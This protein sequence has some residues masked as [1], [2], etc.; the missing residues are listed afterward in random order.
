MNSLAAT[1][2]CP[3][4]PL[5]LDARWRRYRARYHSRRAVASPGGDGAAIRTECCRKLDDH[6]SAV[7]LVAGKCSA[8]H[9]VCWI[10]DA[11]AV[12]SRSHAIIHDQV[13]HNVNPAA[14]INLAIPQALAAGRFPLAVPALSAAHGGTVRARVLHQPEGPNVGGVVSGCQRQPLHL[15]RVEVRDWLAGGPVEVSQAVL[16]SGCTFFRH[17]H[18]A[19]VG[20]R[21]AHAIDALKAAA[22]SFG[23]RLGVVSRRS[24]SREHLITEQHTVV[25]VERLWCGVCLWCL[26]CARRGVAGGGSNRGEG[27]GGGRRWRALRP[28]A[29]PGACPGGIR[30]AA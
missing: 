13:V 6:Y 28:G 2:T 5:G 20:K 29:H 3:K 14:A 23:C 24:D 26:W 18:P 27:L 30:A 17:H 15:P 9:C 10:K 16:H 12:A 1:T 11:K 22:N 21:E 8:S 4:L 25:R 19:R 7:H